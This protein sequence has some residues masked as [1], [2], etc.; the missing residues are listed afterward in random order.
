[1]TTSSDLRFKIFRVQNMAA[2]LRQRDG[3]EEEHGT[4]CAGPACTD[5][6]KSYSNAAVRQSAQSY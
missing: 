1:V 2:R 5:A 3:G 6:G 4:G